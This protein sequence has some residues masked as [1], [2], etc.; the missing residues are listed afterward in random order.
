MPVYAGM[1]TLHAARSA[2]Y[3][4]R[5]SN[6]PR[7]PA[8]LQRQSGFWGA[9][10][11]GGS[12]CGGGRPTLTSK[13][14]PTLRLGHHHAAPRAQA[15]CGAAANAE[16]GDRLHAV[17]AAASDD[18]PI[19]VAGQVK[20]R[21]VPSLLAGWRWLTP[22]TSAVVFTGLER[23]DISD[24][25]GPNWPGS[26]V[27]ATIP[28]ETSFQRSRGAGAAEFDSFQHPLPLGFISSTALG[29]FDLKDVRL[30]CGPLAVAGESGPAGEIS[31]GTGLARLISEGVVIP[32]RKR[33][34]SA[35]EERVL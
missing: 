34:P 26:G 29:Q 6:C 27:Q 30:R 21:P 9:A 8:T 23:F 25:C 35:C 28:Q 33:S 16:T 10:C 31:R 19:A 20:R 2:D 24:S 7:G 5:E 14:Q 15:V 11:G 32:Q 1:R 12:L 22:P 3:T 13:T 4:I 18:P 17:H